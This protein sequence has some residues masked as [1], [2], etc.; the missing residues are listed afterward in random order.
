M[1]TILVVC[2]IFPTQFKA[3]VNALADMGHRIIGI[4]HHANLDQIRDKRNVT[5]LHELGFGNF[6]NNLISFGNGV[7]QLRRMMAE[8]NMSP[9]MLLIHASFGFEILTHMFPASVPVI[10]YFETWYPDEL[11][12]S[13]DRDPRQ[14][15]SAIHTNDMADS[16][17]RRCSLMVAPSK[18]QRSRFPMHIRRKM[19]VIHEGINTD[20]FCPAASPGTGSQK[21]ITFVSTGLEPAKGFMEFIR[22]VKIVLAS[23]DDVRVVIVGEDR[24]HYNMY[25]PAYPK[26]NSYKQLA[27]DEFGSDLMARVSFLGLISKDE[28][29]NVYQKSDLHVHFTVINPSWSLLEAMSCGCVVLVSSNGGILDE[30]TRPLENMLVTDHNDISGTAAKML[31]LLAL[32]PDATA[33]IRKSVRQ[34]VIDNFYGSRGEEVWGSLISPLLPL[35]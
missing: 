16:F 23:M 21:V 33:V 5:V 27:I 13:V 24:V 3:A 14:V 30:I 29:L 8:L 4:C 10:G 20:F 19:F 28:V 26:V 15:M 17:A 18:Y 25:D 11:C 1:K 32:S 35:L 12:L 22:A 2:P 7:I 34:N 6:E 9:D 31:D